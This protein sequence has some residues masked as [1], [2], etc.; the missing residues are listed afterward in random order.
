MIA[1]CPR[2]PLIAVCDDCNIARVLYYLF[3]I[4]YLKGG[5]LAA[6]YLHFNSDKPTEVAPND[7]GYTGR[8]TISTLPKETV[9]LK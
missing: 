6:I 8:E 3:H 9:W 5:R 4:V 7:V 1:Q 2:V